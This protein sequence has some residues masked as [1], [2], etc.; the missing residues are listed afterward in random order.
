LTYAINP[1]GRPYVQNIDDFNEY[2]LKNKLNITVNLKYD[3][4][5]SPLEH[6][7]S[8]VESLLI[9]KSPKYDI[10][11]YDNSFTQ[12]YGPYLL[13]LNGKISEEHIK[14]YHPDIISGSC[15]YKNK[16]VGIVRKTF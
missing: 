12:K 7:K 11:F 3:L 1:E 13:D 15:M 4:Q 10:Y 16:L 8:M 2:S 6:F 9:K 5:G 14:L